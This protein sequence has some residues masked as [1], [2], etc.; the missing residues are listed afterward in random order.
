MRNGIAHRFLCKMRSDLTVILSKFIR[1]NIRQKSFDI[2]IQ[3]IQ[4][5]NINIVDDNNN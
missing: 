2:I 5:E 4:Y 3:N 1:R